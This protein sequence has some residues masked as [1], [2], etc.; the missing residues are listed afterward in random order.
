[1]ASI[2]RIMK[3]LEITNTVLDKNDFA[4]VQRKGSG[5]RMPANLIFSENPWSI[6]NDWDY[7]VL[8]AIATDGSIH[9]SNI[10]FKI[11]PKDVEFSA[12]YLF[13]LTNF[14]EKIHQQRV[15]LYVGLDKSK[16]LGGPMNSITLGSKGFI[17]FLQKILS[18]SLKTNYNVPNFD[19]EK[20]SLYSWLGGLTDGDGYIWRHKNEYGLY[21][22]WDVSNGN[23]EPLKRIKLFLDD[24]V[25]KTFREPSFQGKGKYSL[26]ITNMR[27]CSIFFPKIL[28][29]III[30]RKR[31]RIIQALD[32]LS[33]KGFD[34]K[35]PEKQ[36][37][38]RNPIM[39]NVVVFLREREWLTKL[40]NYEKL[41][42]YGEIL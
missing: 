27:F 14:A 40:Q 28:P 4:Y 32:Y 23:I 34:I 25:V 15:H 42:T 26:R 36:R 39:D 12:A 20:Y 11:S 1:M 5:Y 17:I 35:V 41:E 9:K 38:T 10:Y 18:L 29:Y 19:S 24:S 16:R 33:D 30:E 3:L 2:D 37:N 21:W 31:K 8:G 22:F 6:L 7:Y 13:N